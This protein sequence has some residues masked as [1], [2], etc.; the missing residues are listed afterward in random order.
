[1]QKWLHSAMPDDDCSKMEPPTLA[2]CAEFWVLGQACSSCSGYDQTRY[3]WL[4]HPTGPAKATSA[5]AQASLQGV[6]REAIPAVGE[7][8]ERGFSETGKGRRVGDCMGIEKW[9]YPQDRR[10]ARSTSL[11]SGP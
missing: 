10:W 8:D 7:Y 4:G 5:R 1:M 2:V 11:T 9:V 3:W 6:V